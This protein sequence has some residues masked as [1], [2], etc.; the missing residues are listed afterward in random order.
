QDDLSV[1]AKRRNSETS[2]ASSA[3]VPE[4]TDKKTHQYPTAKRRLCSLKKKEEASQLRDQSRKPSLLPDAAYNINKINRLLMRDDRYKKLYKR[5]SPRWTKKYELRPEDAQNDDVIDYAIDSEVKIRSSE[6]HK[7]WDVQWAR[8]GKGD[9]GFEI[10]FVVASSPREIGDLLNMKDGSKSLLFKYSQYP[11]PSWQPINLIE[12]GRA[13]LVDSFDN[14]N[15]D[16]DF[17]E[18]RLCMELGEAEFKKRFPNRYLAFEDGV[19]KGRYVVC[20]RSLYVNRLRAIEWRWNYICAR[21]GLPPLYIVDWTDE[22]EDDKSLWDLEFVLYLVQSPSVRAMLSNFNQLKALRCEK[23]C[24]KCTQTARTSKISRC[25]NIKQSIDIMDA[26]G[27][28]RM[29]DVGEGSGGPLHALMDFECSDA[30]GCGSSCEN[31]RLQKG[32]QMTLVVFREPTKGWGVRCVSEIQKGAYVTEYIGEVTKH[33]GNNNYEFQM[34]SFQAVTANGKTYKTPLII[35]AEKKGN[36]SRFFAHSCSP[37]TEPIQTIVER[38]GLFFHH[39]AFNALR[40][41]LPGEELTFSYF[42][43]EDAKKK[44]KM[45]FGACSCRS[46]ECHFPADKHSAS[47]SDGSSKKE[48][49]EEKKKSRKRARM[50]VKVEGEEDEKRGSAD[51][52]EEKDE[53]RGREPIG[54]DVH[55]DYEM[56]DQPGP[57]TRS[58][59]SMNGET[60]KR[61]EKITI[62]AMKKEEENEGGKKGAERKRK[63]EE[64]EGGKRVSKRNRRYSPSQY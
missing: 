3:D 34:S 9:T 61:G 4:Q 11:V 53:R 50:E 27:S 21:A 57:S 2:E 45:M 37:N 39:V 60:K 44:I 30:C 24:R 32:R 1:K 59:N 29:V 33:G 46:P 17:I 56:D 7:I 52:S 64:G 43:E 40:R 62:D 51:K 48:S 38:H 10:D 22:L 25:C 15:L 35:G 49:V 36:E 42:G 54:D 12:R 6:G 19:G 16:L 26:R 55:V 28:L 58:S 63:R 18:T 14:R 41:I 47:T 5:C 31:R 13:K 20:Q 23:T 8:S